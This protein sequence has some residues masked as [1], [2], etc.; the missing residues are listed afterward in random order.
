[1]KNKEELIYFKIEVVIGNLKKIF[2][3]NVLETVYTSYWLNTQL[4]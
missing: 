2:Y 1:M 4:N 3:T